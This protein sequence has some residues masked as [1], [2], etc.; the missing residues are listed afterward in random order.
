MALAPH[1]PA[2]TLDTRKGADQRA[3]AARLLDKRSRVAMW[4]GL[5]L[6]LG[7]YGMFGLVPAAANVAVSVTNY[8]GLAGSSISFTGLHNYVALFTTE[9]PG[10]VAS[11]LATVIFVIS[12]SLAQNAFA[13]VLAHRLQGTGRV[14][15]A[16]RV[17]VFLPI[18]LG[19]T[20]VGLLWIL[21]FDPSQGPAEAIANAFGLHSAFLGSY[22][23]AMPIVILVQIWQNVGFSTLVFVGGLR[24]INPDIY[25]AASIDGAGSWRRFASIT[26]P[27]LAP[28]MT[29]NLLLAFVGSL[30]TYN[31]IY[32][33]TSGLYRTDTLGMLAFN[34][35]FGTSADL[36]YGAAVSVVLFLVALGTALPLMAALRHRERRLL[37]A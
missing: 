31:L 4:L 20:I 23:G 3:Q 7:V 33:L 37:P 9:R 14:A 1:R 15:A 19:V 2:E 30:T 27:L 25:E 21:I 16:L 18:V 12:V 36:G 34:S 10:F 13:L 8:S 24:A 22:A 5:T 26:F 6:G 11:L 29:V 32:V 35:A 17:L 28:S